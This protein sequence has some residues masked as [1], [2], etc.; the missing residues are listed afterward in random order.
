MI[1]AEQLTISNKAKT[2]VAELSDLQGAQQWGFLMSTLMVGS[3]KTGQI[4]IFA[5]SVTERDADNDVTGW[6]YQSAALPGW[7][8]IIIND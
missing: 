1:S 5:H 3:P 4:A 7:R 8:L 6:V 2:M